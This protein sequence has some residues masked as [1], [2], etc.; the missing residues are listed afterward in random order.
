[1]ACV[2]YGGNGSKTRV[3]VAR[4]T[5]LQLVMEV[6]EQV[7]RGSLTN[8]PHAAP[9]DAKR[10]RRQTSGTVNAN[11]EGAVDACHIVQRQHELTQ[12]RDGLILFKAQAP[13]FPVRWWEGTWPPANEQ[14]LYRCADRFGEYQLSLLDMRE[15]RGAVRCHRLKGNC[16]DRVSRRL[17]GGDFD[18]YREKSRGKHKALELPHRT[19]TCDQTSGAERLYEPGVARYERYGSAS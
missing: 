1:M 3:L 15:R 11:A 10:R 12:M 9:T 2:T 5:S 14:H 13:L 8:Q 6:P 4:G 19:R 7:R 16:R 18:A 17:K